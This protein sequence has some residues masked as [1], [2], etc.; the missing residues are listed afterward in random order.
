M[1]LIIVPT[2]VPLCTTAIWN[3]TISI[4]AGSTSNAG[5]SATALYNPYDLAFDGYSNLYVVD[6]T[7][8]RIQ[9]FQPGFNSIRS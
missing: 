2:T 5:S 7:N 4:I 3:Q 8:H 6:Y 1:N 9:R